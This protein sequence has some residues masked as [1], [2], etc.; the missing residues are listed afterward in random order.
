MKTSSKP[1]TQRDYNKPSSS[2]LDGSENLKL[3]LQRSRKF[4]NMPAKHM[5]IHNS[6]SSKCNDSI[7]FSNDDISDPSTDSETMSCFKGSTSPLRTYLNSTRRSDLSTTKIKPLQRRQTLTVGLNEN[8]QCVI[9]LNGREDQQIDKLVERYNLSNRE[10]K[11]LRQ[12]VVKAGQG[13]RIDPLKL[14]WE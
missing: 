1:Q 6:F 11:K 5:E 8:L 10:T 7:S 3:L 13:S 9:R 12:L 14:D 2:H 4:S